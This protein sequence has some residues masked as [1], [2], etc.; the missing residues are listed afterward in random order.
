MRTMLVASLSLVLAAT[1]VAAGQE[2][3]FE[4]RYP[5]YRI[6]VGDLL[7]LSFSFTPE[8]NQ[9]V[10]VQP[11]GYITLREAGDIHVADKT[12]PQVVEA[13]R[14]AYGKVLHDPVITL[15]LKEFERPYF[16]V[17]G[18]VMHPGKYD[19]RGDTTVLQAIAVGGG[20]TEGAKHSQVWLFRQISSEWVQTRKL[21]LKK[22]LRSG[23]LSEDLHLRPGDMLYVPKS[24]LAKMKPFI[25]LVTVGTYVPMH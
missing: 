11:D 9:S 13:D 22:M 24:D 5:R 8:F 15:E 19:L 12:M 16:V 10:I 3:A 14:S 18:E 25:P 1:L 23:N 7:V 17:G 21:D 20:F 2:P 6:H 4:E